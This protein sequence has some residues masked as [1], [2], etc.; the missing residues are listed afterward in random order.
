[1]GHE[2]K[3]RRQGKNN[4]NLCIFSWYSN[5]MIISAANAQTVNP[6][7]FLGTDQNMEQ[8]VPKTT[9]APSTI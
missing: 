2:F 5:G 8:N 4:E 6:D 1:M 7:S 9:E 3:S